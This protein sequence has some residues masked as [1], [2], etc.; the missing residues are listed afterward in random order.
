MQLNV[1]FT[2]HISFK[3]GL[4]SINV[5]LTLTLIANYPLHNAVPKR[6]IKATVSGRKST[7]IHEIQSFFLPVPLI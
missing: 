3:A 4:T 5:S 7:V 1:V 2:I 6:V